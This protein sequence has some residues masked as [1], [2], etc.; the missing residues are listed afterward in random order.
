MP[1]NSAILDN[2]ILPG[3]W[4][5]RAIHPFMNISLV[6]MFGRK[7]ALHENDSDDDSEEQ[8][9]PILKDM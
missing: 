5:P 8:Q 7:A 4:F 3:H 1:S 6:F 9:D 2:Y